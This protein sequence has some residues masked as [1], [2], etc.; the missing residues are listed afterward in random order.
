MPMQIGNV[1]FNDRPY[2]LTGPLIQLMTCVIMT[3]KSERPMYIAERAVA[4]CN[5]GVMTIVFAHGCKCVLTTNANMPNHCSVFSP[6]VA[7][8]GALVPTSPFPAPRAY[9]M[10]LAHWHLMSTAPNVTT[11]RALTNTGWNWKQHVPPI[12]P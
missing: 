10:M 9:T 5:P 1:Q 12:N 8:S 6:N 11:W 4:T 2:L 3:C 7:W